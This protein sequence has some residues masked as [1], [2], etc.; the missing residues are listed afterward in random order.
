MRNVFVLFRVRLLFALFPSTLLLLLVRC[1]R[2]PPPPPTTT[3][4][5]IS[6]TIIFSSSSF[7]CYYFT[8]F[9][10]FVLC[11]FVVVGFFPRLLSFFAVSLCFWLSASSFSLQYGSYFTHRFSTI[12]IYYSFTTLWRPKS[13]R[14]QC[15]V[16][17]LT[18]REG[19]ATTTTTITTS[20][21]LTNEHR[22]QQVY[23]FYDTEWI[24][25]HKTNNTYRKLKLIEA[26]SERTK[27][28]NAEMDKRVSVWV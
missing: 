2:R 20:I 27:K 8:S 6:I 16:H 11:V 25:T 13:H 22:P 12:Y 5:T 17:L 28:W 26:V 24:A 1:R 10:K 21:P 23:I 15:H 7:S 9:L 19:T 3:T 18:H 4:T 14:T